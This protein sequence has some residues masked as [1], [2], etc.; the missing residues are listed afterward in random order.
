MAIIVQISSEQAKSTEV[1]SIFPS[2]GSRGNSAIFIPN[3]VSK[4]S[5]SKAPK[6]YNYSKA[7]IIDWTGGGSMKSKFNRSFI[8]IAFNSKIVFAKLVL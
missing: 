1:K 6:L 7:A 3:F 2:G 4:P 8:P 5:S